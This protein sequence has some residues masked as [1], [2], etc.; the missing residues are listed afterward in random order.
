MDLRRLR[1]F[2][3]LAEEL[4]YRVAASRLY[5]TQ[6]ALSRSIAALEREFGVR[7]FERDTRHV[8]LTREGE[9]LL[10]RVRTLLRDADAL[11]QAAG[12]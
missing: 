8:T 4:N 12:A 7:L 3:V 1:N 6:P 10:D 5:L 11:A 9:T 2:L